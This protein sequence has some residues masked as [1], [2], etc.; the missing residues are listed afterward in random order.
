MLRSEN[1]L[2]RPDGAMFRALFKCMEYSEEDLNKPIIAIANSWS[3][4][5]PGHFNLRKV[6]EHVK[7]GVRQA[8][9]TPVE[10]GVIGA[11]D[12]L[13]QTHEGMRYILP[14]RELIA[15]DIEAMVKAHPI[16]AVVLLGSCDKIVPGMLMA[17]TRLNVPAILVNGG[18]MRS[19]RFEKWNAFNGDKMDIAS[20]AEATEMVKSGQMTETD[21]TELEEAA[22]AGPGSCQFLGTANSM[23][24]FA[25]A[26]GLSLPG[27]ATIP[28]VDEERLQTGYLAGKSIMDLLQR[29]ITARKIIGRPSIENA[30]MVMS[31]IGGSTNTVLHCLAL[32]Y[33]AGVDFHLKDIAELS[34]KIPQIAAIMPASKYDMAD[35]H[36]AGGVSAVMKQLEKY[37]HL[38]SMTVSGKTVAENISQSKIN[39]PGVIKTVDQPFAEGGGIVVLYGNIAPDGAVAKKA[40]IPKHMFRFQG[41]AKIFESEQNAIDGIRADKV[42][43]GDVVV[44]RYEGPKG[45]PGMPEMWAPLKILAGKSLLER[46]ALITDGRFSGSNSGLAVGYISPEAQE[47]GPLAALKNGD[48]IALDIENRKIS[49]AIG[50]ERLKSVAPKPTRRRGGYLGLYSKIVSSAAMGAVINPDSIYSK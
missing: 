47:G 18:P 50:K 14:T 41:P 29:G 44:I 37:M 13:A 20:I 2:A 12:G 9:G 7:R 24:C 11:C 15:N 34:A 28:A 17:A 27:T 45:G 33:E 4:V 42:V 6:A 1:L 48:L 39:N 35:F 36:E 16:D 25:E 21:Y 8:G 49:A 19:N 22:A 32:T 43:P 46:V 10:F 40:A 23:C 38:Q 3:T 5:C 31:A 30:I 26:V